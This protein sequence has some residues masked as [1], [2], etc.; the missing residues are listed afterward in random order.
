MPI[1]GS[2]PPTLVRRRLLALLRVVLDFFQR[3]IR[4]D[5]YTLAASLAVLGGLSSGLETV[6]S[7]LRGLGRYLS[8]FVTSSIAIQDRDKLNH[9]VLA[10]LRAHALKGKQTRSPV[11]LR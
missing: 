2:F 9:D 6:S 11:R 10:W 4:K 5:I 3:W 7:I 8:H 1:L